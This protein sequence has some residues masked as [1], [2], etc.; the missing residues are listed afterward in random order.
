MMT[1]KSA[2]LT[3]FQGSPGYLEDTLKLDIR[4]KTLLSLNLLVLLYSLVLLS[5][6]LSQLG[7]WDILFCLFN[8]GDASWFFFFFK[9]IWFLFFFYFFL[10]LW[11]IL[12]YIEMKHPWVYMCLLIFLNVLVE[13]LHRRCLL[14]LWKGRR[15]RVDHLKCTFFRFA[16]NLDRYNLACLSLPQARLSLPYLNN[17]LLALSLPSPPVHS[18]QSLHAAVVV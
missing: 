5:V 13:V 15:H 2:F 17:P 18:P 10:N 9:K 3:L 12:S 11:W 1:L 14:H 7:T 8:W 16:M 4:I 6:F